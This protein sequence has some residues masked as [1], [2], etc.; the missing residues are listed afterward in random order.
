MPI[1]FLHDRFT[2]LYCT[3]QYPSVPSLYFILSVGSYRAC[4]LQPVGTFTAFLLLPSVFW[5]LSLRSFRFL[6]SVWF[7]H[8][9]PFVSFYLPVL[10]LRSFCFFLSVGTFTAFLLLPYIYQC[11]H[12]FPF[13]SFYLS[14]LSLRSFRFLL[15][16]HY[17]HCVPVASFYLSVLSLLCRWLQL[18]QLA[19]G[20]KSRP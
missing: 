6:L 18:A 14:V 11:F 3:C 20:K 1:S 19:K 5:V 7:L 9:V 17:F 12:C 13:A 10:S 16:V 4:F 15:P 2:P 8:C